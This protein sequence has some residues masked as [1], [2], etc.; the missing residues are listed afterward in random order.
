ME[1]KIILTN[2]IGAIAV[3]LMWLVPAYLSGWI[4]NKKTNKL[5][6]PIMVVNIVLFLAVF[7]GA[8]IRSSIEITEIERK[9]DD[10]IKWTPARRIVV[11]SLAKSYSTSFHAATQLMNFNYQEHRFDDSD[12]VK[13]KS[14]YLE[15]ALQDFQK[16]QKSIQINNAA[17]D[18]SLMP[19]VSKYLDSDER[20]LNKLKYYL[21]IHSDD[22]VR[23][24]FVSVPPLD[25]LKTIEGL[26]D[27]LK[28]KYDDIF[29]DR[30]IV[31]PYLK[32]YKE[33]ETIW[34]EAALNTNRLFF[35]PTS[36]KFR[37]GKIP[38]LYDIRNL[39]AL[40][41]EDTDHGTQAQVYTVN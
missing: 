16:L 28:E 26:V 11:R 31:F 32:T 9:K 25:E 22:Y 24:D 8:S 12:K 35:E 29:N 20:L 7:A 18:S 6:K 30:H 41:I 5:N 23:Q 2:Y 38:F 3:L 36:Y 19:I 1:W 34:N 37:K 10:E 17:L 27:N 33:I 15:M 21:L 4:F 13:G 14:I 40:R 39:K